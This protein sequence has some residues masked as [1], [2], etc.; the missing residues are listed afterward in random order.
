MAGIGMQPSWPTS[1]RYFLEMGALD[2]LMHSNT[3]FFERHGWRGV[4]VEANPTSF[5]ALRAARPASLNI[6]MAAC[7][8]A[9]SLNF[10][11]KSTTMAKIRLSHDRTRAGTA[12]ANK[13]C[14]CRAHLWAL[15]SP[16]S[17]LTQ[18]TF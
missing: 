12:R 5:R 14:R 16:N 9:G 7:A 4:L 11:Q 15:S 17:G 2:G 13:W 18:S 6:H 8:T 1:E 10:S 3:L